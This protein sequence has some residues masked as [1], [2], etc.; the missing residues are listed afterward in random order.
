MIHQRTLQIISTVLICCF[1]TLVWAKK[2]PEPKEDDVDELGLVSVMIKDKHYDRALV[3]LGEINPNRAG[4]DKGKYYL[5]LGLCHLS[6]LNAQ[7][8]YNAL[9]KAVSFTQ[10]DK[11]AY[12]FLAQAAFKLE[13]YKETISYI[14]KGGEAATALEATYMLKANAFWKLND[15][16]GAW[17]TLKEGTKRFPNNVE[18]KRSTVLVLVEAGLFQQ[19]VVEGKKFLA[20]ERATPD[21]YTAIS[22]AFLKGGAHEEA[23]LVLEAARLSFPNEP[24]LTVQLAR[25]YMKSGNELISARLFHLASLENEDFTTDAAE[26]YRRKGQYY[27]ALRLNE[28]IVDQKVKIRQRMGILIEMTRFEE[29]AALAPRLFRLGLLEEAPIQYGLAYSYFKNGAFN[30]AEDILSKITDP[31]Y[32]TKAMDLRLAIERCVASGW[33]CE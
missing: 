10:K 18:M 19:A 20:D 14:E 29:A 27:K 15:L 17:L 25:A 22:E 24:K 26:L 9:K 8:A 30:K 16:H 28:K 13:K 1:T 31:V 2:A 33:Q 12:V 21:D 7:D 4:M 32:F 5:Y 23:I 3:L 6:L 11:M